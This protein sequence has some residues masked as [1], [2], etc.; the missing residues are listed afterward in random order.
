MSA[1]HEVTNQVPPL[2]GHD[3][4]AGDT[5]LVEACRRHADDA[6]LASLAELGRLAGSERAQEWGRLANENPPT[7]RTHDRYGHRVD[8]VEFY[9]F[10]HDLMRTALVPAGSPATIGAPTNTF[11][12][13]GAG[14][15]AGLELR[16]EA[17]RLRRH[18]ARGL[19][20]VLWHRIVA[21]KAGVERIALARAEVA[22]SSG[23]RAAFV[24]NAG[25]SVRGRGGR[26][27]LRRSAKQGERPPP[28]GPG[29]TGRCTQRPVLFVGL[30]DVRHWSAEYSRPVNL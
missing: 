7:L 23:H 30:R 13:P 24:G 3:P 10:W 26:R 6:A 21:S 14:A 29:A 17:P 20:R 27:Q 12:L 2:V 22:E 18:P 9:P 15:H 1:T 8:E 4:I 28:D 11:L 5:V 16:D 19:A 25:V